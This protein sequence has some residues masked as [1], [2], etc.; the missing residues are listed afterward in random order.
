M[1][2]LNKHSVAETGACGLPIGAMGVC[3]KTGSVVATASVPHSRGGGDA[4]KFLGHR[5]LSSFQFA[6][7]SI[8][9]S[10]FN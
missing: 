8:D 3:C 7:R 10:I 5:P 2:S 6:D 9:H 4:S 1:E